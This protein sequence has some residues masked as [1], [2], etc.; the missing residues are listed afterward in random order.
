MSAKTRRDRCV[1]CG[2]A[3]TVLTISAPRGIR[4]A[5]CMACVANRVAVTVYLDHDLPLAG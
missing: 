1:D 2:A 3:D 5:F 4:D